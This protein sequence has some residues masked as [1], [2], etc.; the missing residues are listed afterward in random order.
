MT[1]HGLS[2]HPFYGRWTGMLTRCYNPKHKDYPF[3]GGIGIGMCPEWRSDPIDF[4]I[5]LNDQ[6][7][8]GEWFLDRID[9]S[10]GYSPE[11]CR[12]VNISVSN[13]NRNLPSTKGYVGVSWHIRREKYQS[14]LSVN[15]KKVYLGIYTSLMDAVVAREKYIISNGLPHKRNLN[16]E[17]H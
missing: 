6:G 10:K 17:P 2:G 1:T 15:D 8:E 11:N 7:T 12:C 3:Y 4:L 13:M 14:S 16:F 9:N 5:W